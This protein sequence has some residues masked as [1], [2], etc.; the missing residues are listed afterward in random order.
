MSDSYEVE[1]KIKNAPLLDTMRAYGYKT[2]AK[3]S[4]ASGIQ[5][6]EIG[7]AVNLKISAF[8]DRGVMHR[9][10]SRLVDFFQCDITDLCPQE[11]MNDPLTNNN[12][13]FRCSWGEPSLYA[14]LL[15]S[16]ANRGSNCPSLDIESD[17][18]ESMISFDSLTSDLY[19][20]KMKD[21]LR[22][23]FIENKNLTEIC[24][25]LEVD[26]KEAQRIIAA[27]LSKLRRSD[28]ANRIHRL[29]Y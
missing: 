4:S 12:A 3:L 2:N 17:E 28:A 20:K 1:M 23:R 26:R 6:S 10:Y 22:M 8:D 21:A 15:I 16:V 5:P 14:D 27:G 29:L 19:G 18:K 24:S 11:H 9:V 25:A 7:L 13:V